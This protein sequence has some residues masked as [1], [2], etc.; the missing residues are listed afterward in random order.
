MKSKTL[1]LK[2]ITNELDFLKKINYNS[3]KRLSKKNLLLVANKLTKNMPDPRNAEEQYQS[4]IIKKNR[5]SVKQSEIIT[6]VP[7]TFE[8]PNIVEIKSIIT[9][10]PKTS[11]KLSKTIRQVEKIGFNSS[12][13]K[14]TKKVKFF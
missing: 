4:F 5:K 13:Y 8:N 14:D 9:E 12:S 6:Y 7:R 11:N 3:M 2:T 1:S 10:H